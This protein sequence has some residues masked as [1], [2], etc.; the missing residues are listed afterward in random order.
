MPAASVTGGFSHAWENDE[1]GGHGIPNAIPHFI[2]VFPQAFPNGV[3]ASSAARTTG[4]GTPG[5][6]GSIPESGGRCYCPAPPGGA[7]IQKYLS[8][9]TEW[10]SQSDYD[11]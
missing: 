2:Q 6:S 1:R 3:P 9:G 10:F 4:C 5:I 7:D 8:I 11:G